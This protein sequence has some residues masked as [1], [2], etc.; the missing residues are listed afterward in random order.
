[1][2]YAEGTGVVVRLMQT[3]LPSSMKVQKRMN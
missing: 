1:M 3:L 2:S